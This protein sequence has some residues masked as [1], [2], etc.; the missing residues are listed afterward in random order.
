MRRKRVEWQCLQWWWVNACLLICSH[1]YLKER[2]RF[3][4][5]Y[6]KLAAQLANLESEQIKLKKEQVQLELQRNS[7]EDPQ[8]VELSLIRHLGLI[9]KESV[10]VIF[11]P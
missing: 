6:A 3:E 7:W 5:R 9:P 2:R 4:E 8:W 10:K 1:F 11:E